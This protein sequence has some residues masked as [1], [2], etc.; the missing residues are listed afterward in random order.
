VRQFF[1]QPFQIPTNSMWPSYNGMVPEVHATP[2][3][4]P[5]AASRALRYFA[6]GASTFRINSPVD[7][8]ILI[9]RDWQHMRTPAKGRTWLVFPQ[10]QYAYELYVAGTKGVTKISINVPRDFDFGLVLRDTFA[11]QSASSEEAISLLKSKNGSVELTG[12]D[13]WGRSARIQFIRTGKHVRAGERMLSFDIMSGDRLFVDRLSYHFTRPSVGEGFVFHTTNIPGAT[14][15]NMNH[16]DSYYIKRLA[17]VP[18]DTLQI[19]PPVLLRNGEPIT[20]AQAFAD[21]AARAGKY[22]GYVNDVRGRY[23]TSP[24][25]T[26]NVSNDGYIALGDNSHNSQDSRYWGEVPKKDVVGRPLWVFYPF[27]SHWGP[28]R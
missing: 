12:T 8:E 16:I 19:R 9:P 28:A 17:G 18:G 27:N 20:G 14:D 21:N 13:D 1:F 6:L 24:E 3:D 7:G 2:A 25:K 11:P 4:E 23:L 15:G 10:P 5:G 22:H 26:Y